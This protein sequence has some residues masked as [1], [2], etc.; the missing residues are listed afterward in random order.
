MSRVQLLFILHCFAITAASA[1]TQSQLP[2]A[3]QIQAYF[4]KV[5]SGQLAASEVAEIALLLPNQQHQKH[6]AIILVR[7]AE[8]IR[9]RDLTQV[10]IDALITALPVLQS[11][12]RKNALVFLLKHKV[13]TSVDALEK[14]T[15]SFATSI[16]GIDLL[17]LKN[18]YVVLTN[19]GLTASEE[20]IAA[21]HGLAANQS[22]NTAV[23]RTA[24]ELLARQKRLSAE[25]LVGYNGPVSMQLLV[26][27]RNLPLTEQSVFI[28]KNVV[29]GRL[30][31]DDQRIFVR[32]TLNKS[33]SLSLDHVRA[34]IGCVH[35]KSFL[36]NQRQTA[37]KILADQINKES[38]CAGIALVALCG[39]A[40][41]SFVPLKA[42]IKKALSW[43]NSTLKSQQVVQQAFDN[44]CAALFK[45]P[46][47]LVRDKIMDLLLLI[48]NS[49]NA[50]LSEQST[51]QLVALIKS[52]TVATPKE[53]AAGTGT[54]L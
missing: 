34:M 2:L 28:I 18:L 23:R 10:V 22:L 15:A 53:T 40:H 12:V 37:A 46:N 38:S 47:R 24:M 32:N 4:T 31:N 51:K 11:E 5:Y 13:I 27:T 52:K 30:R 35:N 3:N 39:V 1:A 49:K 54:S 20:V 17:K 45:A 36:K 19:N 33:A 6:A 9:S 29:K 48:S 50:V 26:A 43:Q 14:I 42:I 16:P 7:A 44:L 41:H 8:R 25:L 21:L